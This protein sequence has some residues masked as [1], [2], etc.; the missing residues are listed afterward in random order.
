MYLN[1]AVSVSLDL[2]EDVEGLNFCQYFDDS[3]LK[4]CTSHQR[5]VVWCRESFL[6]DL[7]FLDRLHTVSNLIIHLIHEITNTISR[8]S[9]CLI[10]RSTHF[11]D[12]YVSL[13]LKVNRFQ[14]L[15]A[16][17]PGI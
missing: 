12:D 7:N 9:I 4:S 16:R 2:F 6:S 15:Y 3:L 17:R 1:Y 10:W 14:N 13:L 11:K 8:W 5:G